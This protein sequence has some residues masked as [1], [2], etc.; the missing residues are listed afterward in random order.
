MVLP[1][2]GKQSQRDPKHRPD[3][4][5]SVFAAPIKISFS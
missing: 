4:Y 3:R 1:A 5:I 2:I